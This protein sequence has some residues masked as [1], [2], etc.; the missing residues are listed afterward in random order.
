MKDN[1]QLILEII[2]KSGKVIF[3]NHLHLINMNITD[4]TII[5]ESIQNMMQLLI[6]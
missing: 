1:K 6:K 3:Y 2:I 5:F 4:Y